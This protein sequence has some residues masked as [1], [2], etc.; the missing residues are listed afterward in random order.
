V[1]AAP[2]ARGPN[3]PPT[4][5]TVA[6]VETTSASDTSIDAF[7]TYVY[8]VR[9]LA[10]GDA[11]SAPSNEVTVGPPPVGFTSVIA[12]PKAMQEK[13]PGQFASQI[14]MAFD[15]NG[16]PMVAY[17]SYDINSDGDP[18][19]SEIAFASWNRA[20]HRW[21]PPVHV[22]TVGN[23]SR[24]GSNPPLA[25][26]R[27][28]AS[29]TIGLLYLVGD[30]EVRLSTS[31]DNGAT[32]KGVMID[33]QSSEDGRIATPSLVFGGGRVHVAYFVGD[34][35]VRYRSGRVT[36]ASST[37]TSEKAPTLAGTGEA[38]SEGITVGLDAAGKP[39]V[40]YWLNP[41]DGYSLTLAAGR[42]GRQS[43]RYGW[44]PDRR[45]RPADG[46]ERQPDFD[47]VLRQSR[48]QVLREPPDLVRPLDRRRRDMAA[49]R[50][51]RQ[52][53]RQHDGHADVAVDRQ[54]GTRG[55]FRRD[56]GRQQHRH[57]LRRAEAPAIDRRLEVDGLRARDQ[58][59]E[60][61]RRRHRPHARLRRQ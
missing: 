14:R 15:A 58:G 43:H 17:L 59:R 61:G 50:R 16:D 55:D 31:A 22:D 7:A 10:A 53:R 34:L 38:R 45:S 37:W 11:L 32:W 5:A 9:G 21:N 18:A 8:R 49:A 30:R 60:R 27:D 54:I 19:D 41:A 56:H 6:T 39:G 4:P 44:P 28:D 25:I 3:A 48:R 40:T 26:A 46:H 51:H 23:V 29:G 24:Q 33:R 12:A 47:R 13:E 2:A 36:D 52:R 1:P 42:R 57:S 20:R 35:G